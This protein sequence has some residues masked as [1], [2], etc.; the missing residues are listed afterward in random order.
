MYTNRSSCPKVF[1]KKGVLKNF[2]KLI[3]KKPATL[4]KKTFWRRCFLVNFY[5]T[6][7]GCFHTNK[8][9][10]LFVIWKSQ[11]WL[12]TFEICCKYFHKM[13]KVLMEVPTS[14]HLMFSCLVNARYIHFFSKML[15]IHRL[16]INSL[17]ICD[18]CCKPLHV[19]LNYF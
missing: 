19:L 12:M 1:C 10:F 9:V 6:S 14:K 7:G 17:K 4:L 2:V 3:G 16:R 11:Q 5:N 8:L 15:K 13:L 18:L